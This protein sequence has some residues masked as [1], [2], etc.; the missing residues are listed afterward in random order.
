[1][2]LLEFV[3]IVSAKEEITTEYIPDKDIEIS[4]LNT[5]DE[6]L[7]VIDNDDY[8]DLIQETP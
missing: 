3:D 2:L 4:L 7:K 6:E 8:L 1:M 5:N